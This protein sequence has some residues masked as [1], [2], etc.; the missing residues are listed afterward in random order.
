[1]VSA[2][3]ADAQ[4]RI[5]YNRVKGSMEDQL[6]TMGFK[7][8]TIVRPSMLG[9]NREEFRLGEKVASVLLKL[10]QWMFVGRLRRYRIVEDH[11]VASAMLAAAGEISTGVRIIESEDIPVLAAASTAN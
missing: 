4:S 1:M 2:I 6:R 11:D 3:G 7:Q 5:F 9:G 10:T 8:L